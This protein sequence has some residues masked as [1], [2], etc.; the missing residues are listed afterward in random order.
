MM[1]RSGGAGAE[2]LAP[3]EQEAPEGA[4]AEALAPVGLA[5]AAPAAL[6]QPE[7]E[8]GEHQIKPFV[9]FSGSIM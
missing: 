9:T 6:N 1:S 4:G 3:L 5:L 7:P 8:A 2:D